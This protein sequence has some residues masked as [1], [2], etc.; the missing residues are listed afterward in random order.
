MALC[1]HGE[2]TDPDG[3]RVRPRGGVH[4]AASSRRCCATCPAL[5][6]VFE[7][8]TTERGGRSSSR[9][10]GRTSRR[11][12][13]RSTCTSTATRCSSAASART[14]IACRSPSARRTGWRCARR[15][16]RARPSSSSAPT[17]RRTRARPRK[18]ACGC[19]GIFNAPFAL[20]SYAAVFD[21]EGALDRF[22]GF[23][24]EHGP[25]FYGLPL[26]EGTVTLERGDDRGARHDRRRRHPGRAVPRRRDAQAGDWRL[27]RARAA[28]AGPRRTPRSR[29]RSATKQ[30]S[31]AGCSGSP[32]TV[33]PEHED[34]RRREEL[35][36]AERRIVHPP[37]RDR[38]QQQRHRGQRA[39]PARSA[40]LSASSCPKRGARR[41][42]RAYQATIAS[43]GSS[44]SADSIVS[45][46]SEPDRHQLA[47]QAVDAE[48]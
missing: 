14:P 23:A 40:A 18:A 24:C 46:G 32:N 31:C 7:H 22:E 30:A 10:P 26:N 6:V 12:S 35:D 5:K 43:A 4:R 8:V 11:R 21:E 39:R 2:V 17:A 1:V 13:P 47:E 9:A 3:R 36:E 15:R 45:P 38:E 29:P 34:D 27:S 41:A 37:R 48:S 42:S 19:A 44:S 33:R 20:E 25:R 16:P 28:P